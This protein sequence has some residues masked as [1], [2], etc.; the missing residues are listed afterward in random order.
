MTDPS[1]GDPAAAYLDDVARMLAD[2]NP[3]DRAEVLAGLREHID[4]ALADGPQPPTAERVDAVLAELGPP[5]RVAA[6]ALAD[7]SPTWTGAPDSPAA[8]SHQSV[9]GPHVLPALAQAW[10]PVLVGVLLTL[11]TL[12]VLGI[13]LP[14]LVRAGVASTSATEAGGGQNVLLPTAYD[15]VW[16]VV[17]MLAL[18]L[19][20]WVVTSA[21]LLLSP[22]WGSRQKTVGVALL[23]GAALAV[24]VVVVLAAVVSGPVGLLLGG[25]GMVGVV[26]AAVTVLARLWRDGATRARAL[27]P[28]APPGMPG[29]WAGPGVGQ[30]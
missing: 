18:A 6:E 13:G 8:P 16:S 22:L 3:L 20:G 25:A 19:P 12:V 21:L 29:A 14:V 10:V 23:P 1:P 7:R 28:P 2:L 27:R 30:W 15:F 5:D 9:P 26:V 11:G 4:A 17:I 24:A